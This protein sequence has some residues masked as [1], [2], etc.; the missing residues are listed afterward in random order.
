MAKAPAWTPAE[1]QVLRD[2]YPAQGLIAAVA[3]LPGRSDGAIHQKAHK[4]GLKTNARS[5]RTGSFMELSGEAWRL[6]REEGLSYSSIG[7]VL[8]ICEANATNAVLYAE[9]VKAGHRTIERTAGGKLLPEGRDRLRVLFR[10][11]WTHR[12]IQEWTGAPASMLTRERKRYSLELK[13]KRLAPLPP[14]GGGERHSGAKIPRAIIREVERLYLEGFGA[15]RITKLT[16]VSNTHCLRVRTKLIRR[17]KRAGKRLPGC[18]ET[19]VRRVM[20]D[21]G[22][23]IPDTSIAKF[24]RL[25]RQG[26]TVARAAKLSIIGRSS[27][28][29]IVKAMIADGFVLVTKPWRGRARQA[30]QLLNAPELPGARWGIDRYRAHIHAGKPHAQAVELVRAEWTGKVEGQRAEYAVLR[31]QRKIEQNRP[32]SFEEQVAAVERGAKLVAAFRPTRATPDM[33]L[34]GVATGALG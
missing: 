1:I 30:M 32:K 12:K 28:D 14:I 29:K 17:L 6:K 21:H 16:G 2:L 19:G 34:G 31:A 11:G 22:R 25:I 9:C 27:A 4:L 18:D 23:R 8:G 33:T 24:K 5:F 26:E 20:K 10:K 15:A 3:G 13:A 7:V